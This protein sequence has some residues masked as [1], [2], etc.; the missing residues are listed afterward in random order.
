MTVDERITLGLVACILA[1]GVLSVAPVLLG[2][3][4]VEPFSELGILGPN[5][6]L[7]DYPK[8]GV[9][10]EPFDL[11]LYLGNHEGNVQYYQVIVNDLY[12]YLG[13][14]EGNVQY[15]QVI[16]KQGD[17]SQNVTEDTPLDAPMITIYEHSLINKQN[18]TI[19]IS[20]APIRSGIYQR[21]VFELYRY[22]TESQGF[23]YNGNWLQL[24]MNVTDS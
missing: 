6:K 14:H 4:V 22:D 17:Q 1:F 15:Y 18:T 19:P 13:N 5:M 8:D 16:V 24:W 10:G 20:L 11:Y 12:L 23:E 9:T 2:K 7:G 21:I 3:R